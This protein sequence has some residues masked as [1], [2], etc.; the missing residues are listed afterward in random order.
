MSCTI[1]STGFALLVVL[2]R[3]LAIHVDRCTEFLGRGLWFDRAG[4]AI[5]WG[6]D[7]GR[8]RLRLVI[9]RAEGRHFTGWVLF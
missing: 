7:L 9:D 4:G 1:T 8:L 3:Q 6:L 5:S 2:G